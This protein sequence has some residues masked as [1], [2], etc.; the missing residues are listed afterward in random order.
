MNYNFFYYY[1]LILIYG[2]LACFTG[3]F[4]DEN[5]YQIPFDSSYIR[6][7]PQNYILSYFMTQSVFMLIAIIQ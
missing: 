5:S 2:A 3:F 6:L 1:A 7:T 4:W